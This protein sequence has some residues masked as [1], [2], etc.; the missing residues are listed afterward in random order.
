MFRVSPKPTTR[1]FAAASPRATT[2]TTGTGTGTGTGT[3]AAYVFESI[4]TSG[5]SASFL[6]GISRDMRGLSDRQRS[7]KSR[8]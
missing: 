6:A 7:S 8:G 2:I 3:V 4:S 1:I 5:V